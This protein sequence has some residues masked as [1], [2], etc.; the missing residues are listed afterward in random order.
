MKKVSLSILGAIAIIIGCKTNKPNSS[1]QSTEIK[2]DFVAKS[3]ST[4][5]GNASFIEKNGKVTFTAHLAG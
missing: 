4:I 3:N 1:A 2:V 5:S